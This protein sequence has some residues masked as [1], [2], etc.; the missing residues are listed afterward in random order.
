MLQLLTKEEIEKSGFTYEPDESKCKTLKLRLHFDCNYFKDGK[1]IRRTTPELTDE[2]K[3]NCAEA[4]KRDR[5]NWSFINLVFVPEIEPW[6][7]QGVMC[8]WVMVKGH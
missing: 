5:P 4:L 7:G 3:L 8:R 2:W 1:F 6:E